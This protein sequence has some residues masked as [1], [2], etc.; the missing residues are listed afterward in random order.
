MS[1][2]VSKQR[3]GNW[4]G[5]ERFGAEDEV[6]VLVA[7][8]DKIRA[9]RDGSFNLRFLIRLLCEISHGGAEVS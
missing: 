8:C 1:H 6:C 3:R 2:E 4:I 9:L 5:I 7:S